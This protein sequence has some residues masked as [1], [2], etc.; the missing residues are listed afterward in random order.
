MKTIWK[1][2]VPAIDAFSI[3]MP[4]GAQFLAVQAQHENAQS[5][6]LVDDDALL[7][8]RY[9]RVHGTG[10]EVYSPGALT[11]LGTFQLNDGELVFHLFEERK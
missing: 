7:K 9:F 11:F 10:H 2:P 6:W 8:R 5:W 3:T 4:A 1:Y